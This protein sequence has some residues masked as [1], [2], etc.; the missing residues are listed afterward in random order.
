M[1]SAVCQGM[2]IAD[3]PSEMAVNMKRQV[4]DL[5]ARATRA[6]SSVLLLQTLAE[7]TNVA[8]RK[9]RIPVKNIG[10]PFTHGVRY[11]RYERP[12]KA[13]L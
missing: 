11:C 13:I 1:R 4:R 5:I 2:S 6:G 10:E 9:V 3:S 12:T 7:F 8:I